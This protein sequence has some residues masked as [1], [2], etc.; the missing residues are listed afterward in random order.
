[1]SFYVHDDPAASEA[2]IHKGSCSFC[3]NGKGNQSQPKQDYWSEAYVSEEE[4]LASV[5]KSR[6]VRVCKRC[7]GK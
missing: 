1:M 3:N 6:S 2:I 7:L 4:V 5:K